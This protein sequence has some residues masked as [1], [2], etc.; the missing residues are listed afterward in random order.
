MKTVTLGLLLVLGIQAN[1]LEPKQEA[2]NEVCK[3]S[4]ISEAA[5][6]R[7]A[8]ELGVTK[9]QRDRLVCNNLPMMEFAKVYRDSLD[10]LPAS[11]AEQATTI[12]N[13]Q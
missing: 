6:R 9:S 3:A 13:I 8:R 11:S 7:T 12:V 4:L 5:A 2:L 1:A 10:G